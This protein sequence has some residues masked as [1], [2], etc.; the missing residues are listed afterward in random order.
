M[1]SENQGKNIDDI[2]ALE[3]KL[4]HSKRT[5]EKLLEAG[6]IGASE[7][8]SQ[9]A[10]IDRQFKQLQEKMS[11]SIA[12]M[13]F[14]ENGAG[15]KG[16]DGGEM[17]DDHFDESIQIMGVIRGRSAGKRA[18]EVKFFYHSEACKAR[19]TNDKGTW[20]FSSNARN[21]SK[22]AFVRALE[23]NNTA[24]N[25]FHNEMSRHL[26]DWEELVAETHPE[27]FPRKIQEEFGDAMPHEEPAPLAAPTGSLAPEPTDQEVVIHSVEHGPLPPGM[28]RKRPDED[29]FFLAVRIDVGGHLL[30]LRVDTDTGK[31]KIP[32]SKLPA[33]SVS[34]LIADTV[35]AVEKPANH[36]YLNRMIA[37]MRKNRQPWQRVV[38]KDAKAF[39]KACR[40]VLHEDPGA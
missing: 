31:W 29:H 8:T 7:Y 39:P 23:Q 1:E 22:G 2:A 24:M 3:Q 6:K 19:M 34:T 5:L 32:P 15:P 9:K 13:L 12:E 10:V 16:F 25:S 11:D 30:K 26:D 33:Q 27:S 35:T 37:E 4:L 38:Q 28:V 36:I 21:I 40:D 20:S 14:E 18:F 17:E